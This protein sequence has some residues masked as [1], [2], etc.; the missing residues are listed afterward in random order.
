MRLLIAF[1]LPWR[2]FFTMGRP[3]AGLLCLLLQIT[4]M[5]WIPA[6]IWTVYSLSQYKTDQKIACKDAHHR[7]MGVHDGPQ[8]APANMQERLSE[9]IRRQ[10]R[11]IEPFC[12]GRNWLFCDSV[13][14]VQASANLKSPT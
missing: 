10:D 14:G 2:T 13:R 6:T 7:V 4:L 5:G 9:E 3:I 1:L 11:V 12:I 8:Y